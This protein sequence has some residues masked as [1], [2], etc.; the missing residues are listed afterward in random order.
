[1]YDLEYTGALKLLRYKRDFVISNFA[2]SI[3]SI[4]KYIECFAGDSQMLRNKRH[5][6]I[7]LIA[8]NVFYCRMKTDDTVQIN[9]FRLPKILYF[10]KK[11]QSELH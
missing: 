9:Q 6:V 2:V 10:I 7:S 4:R 8:I 11:C 1:M 5:F 3:K